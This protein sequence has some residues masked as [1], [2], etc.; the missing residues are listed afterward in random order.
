MATE[1][2]KKMDEILECR[3]LWAQRTQRTDN[4]SQF[5]RGSSDQNENSTVVARNLKGVGAQGQKKAFRK[6]EKKYFQ[7]DKMDGS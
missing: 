3:G 6:Q 1:D 4:M 7:W 2:F 5:G